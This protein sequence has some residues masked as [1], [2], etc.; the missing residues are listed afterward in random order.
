MKIIVPAIGSRGD[1]QPYIN[2]CQGLQEAGHDVVLATNPTLVSLAGSHGVKCVPVGPPVDMGV[3]GA[4]LMA[5]SFNNMW[6]GMIRVMQL[7]ARLVEE[8]YPDVLKICQGAD[9][10]ITSDT[11]SGIVEADRLNI[12]WI[13]VT[14]QPGRIPVADANTPFFARMI[15][16]MLGKLFIAPTNRFRKR[17][18]VQPVEDISRLMSS[19]LI[20]LPVSRH[21]APPDSRW[22]RHIVQ[23]GYWFPR[24]DRIWFPPRDLLDFLERGNKPIAVSLGVMSMS[25]KQAGESVRIVLR[26]IERA[27]VRA[28][29]QGWD[30]ALRDLQLP[31]TVC[32]IGSM[33][34]AWL[35]DQVSMVI[36]HGG[37]GTT[38][39]V[40]RAGVP[41]IVIPHVIDQFYWGQR[42]YE[43][44]V[45]PKWI[46]RG[47]LNPEN[48]SNAILQARNDACMRDKARE[49]GS[50]IRAEEDG[51]S[52]AVRAIESCFDQ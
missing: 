8:A 38:A 24:P 30:E 26:A 12:P 27:G 37:F 31:E 10:V 7:G 28:V 32:A 11:G 20:L 1:V 40:L 49:L 51:V 22:P 36:H 50:R 48:L 23:T 44:G 5:Q 42:V 39:A 43:L 2:L 15:W 13:S 14:L 25:G 45:S 29:I 41:G 6:I 35:F 18:G 16:G 33:P 21:V 9:L 47:K 4:R 34:H 3:E 17:A 19:R 52:A 46:P